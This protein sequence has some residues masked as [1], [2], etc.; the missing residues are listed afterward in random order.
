MAMISLIELRETYLNLQLAWPD[1]WPGLPIIFDQ[2]VNQLGWELSAMSALPQTFSLY[3]CSKEL[4][5]FIEEANSI[6][7]KNQPITVDCILQTRLLG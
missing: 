3:H 6:K 5:E 4:A 7:I 1:K 2:C